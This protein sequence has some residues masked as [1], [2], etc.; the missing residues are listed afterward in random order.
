MNFSVKL[1][2]GSGP[3]EMEMISKLLF[4][5]APVIVVMF[6]KR[7]R[8]SDLSVGIFDSLAARVSLYGKLPL[9]GKAALYGVMTYYLFLHGAAAQTFIYFQ[10]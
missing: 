9:M 7:A 1:H 10:F 2:L 4:F 5:S 8:E 3:E 6:L